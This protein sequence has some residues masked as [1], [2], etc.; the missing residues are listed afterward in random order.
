M[1][2]EMLY[3]VEFQLQM[4]ERKGCVLMAVAAG[5]AAATVMCKLA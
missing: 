4:L 5:S 3:N 2:Q 1:Q